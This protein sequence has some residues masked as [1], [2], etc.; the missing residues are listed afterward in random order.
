[1]KKC[2]AA[3]MT[4]KKVQNK[5]EKHSPGIQADNRDLRKASTSSSSSSPPLQISL[6]QTHLPF[7]DTTN[8]TATLPTFSSYEKKRFQ[9]V[10]TFG[11]QNLYQVT[12][13]A[14][15][16]I[17]LAFELVMDFFPNFDQLPFNDKKSLIDG[18]VK[19]IWQMEPVLDNVHNMVTYKTMEQEDIKNV[20]VSLLDGCFEE[21]EE[22]S[23]EQIWRTFGSLWTYFYKQIIEPIISISLDS[24][25]LMAVI[26]ILFFDYAYNDISTTSAN[27]CW[28]I[29]KVIYR[30]LKNYLIEKF[31]G[32]S[33]A[34]ESRFF[35]VLEVPIIVE[36]AEQKF[37]DEVLLLEMN[38]VRVHEDFL[39]I[40]KKERL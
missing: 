21:G 6:V 3:G 2:L 35:E 14:R 23:D 10:S 26:W 38:R 40:M 13:L 39:K 11:S 30:E 5:R 31:R 37:Q 33:G 20:L 16:E 1:M 36:R 17:N 29:R 7:K 12:S 15:F 18:Y 4:P 28:N 27:V 24:I 22:M 9:L 19:K 8:I 25:E 32:D 34:A